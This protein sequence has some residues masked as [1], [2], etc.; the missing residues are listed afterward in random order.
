MNLNAI[1]PGWRLGPSRHQAQEPALL[2][3][4]AKSQGGPLAMAVDLASVGVSPLIDKLCSKKIDKINQKLGFF[5][6]S[7][8]NSFQATQQQ[9]LIQ[10]LF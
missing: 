3:P 5:N 4:Q 9:H 2:L 10:S 1:D 6:E 8:Q 7:L